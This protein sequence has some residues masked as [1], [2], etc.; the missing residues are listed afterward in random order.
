M[1][2]ISVYKNQ[3][4]ISFEGTPIYLFHA[5]RHRHIIEHTIAVTHKTN[6]MKVN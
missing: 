5:I 3:I 2:R 1:N 6:I 4:N